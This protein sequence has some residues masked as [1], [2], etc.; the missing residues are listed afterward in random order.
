MIA[1]SREELEFLHFL[2]EVGTAKPT[3]LNSPSK[4]SPNS[5]NFL[6]ADS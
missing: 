2:Q 1:F 3:P 5:K 4:I 6:V